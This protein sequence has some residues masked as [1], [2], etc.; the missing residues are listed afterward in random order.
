MD[1]KLKTANVIK[2]KKFF[3]YLGASALGVYSLLHSPVKLFFK[4]EINKRSSSKISVR[5]NP[6]AVKRNDT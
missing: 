6:L 2:R 4:K 3:Y 5:Q 1:K